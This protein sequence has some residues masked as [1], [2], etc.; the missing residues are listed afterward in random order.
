MTIYWQPEKFQCGNKGIGERV[1]KEKGK[2]FREDV[3][4]H[5]EPEKGDGLSKSNLL[6][7]VLHL[8]DLCLKLNSVTFSGSSNT[9][10]GT[11]TL[12]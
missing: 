1:N 9:I 7:K 2:P 8:G 10:L 12:N 5:K 11:A 3:W 6:G 4:C